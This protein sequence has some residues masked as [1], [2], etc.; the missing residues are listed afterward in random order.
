MKLLLNSTFKTLEG[1]EI[2]EN[3]G[4]PDGKKMTLKGVCAAAL[5]SP[6]ENDK[7]ITGQE[8]A[9]RYLLA[10]EIHNSDE[11][12]DL[13]SED[14]SL[15]KKLIGNMYTPLIVGQA[16]AMLEGKSEKDKKK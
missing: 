6:Q 9:K 2:P 4:N 7:N 3:A 12:I 8:K 13:E 1:K 5:L 10:Q 11:S 16:Y 14:I 15:L